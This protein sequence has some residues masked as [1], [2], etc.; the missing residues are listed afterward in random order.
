MCFITDLNRVQRD[1]GPVQT[2]LVV[3]KVQ[4]HGLPETGQRQGLVCACGQ[5]KAMDGVPHGVQDELI[6]L[7]KNSGHE[8]KCHCTQASCYRPESTLAGTSAS[9][10]F[11]HI[12]IRVVV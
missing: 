8:K 6:A 11:F 3:V 12:D 1:V 10:V 9:W 5:V 2:V 4:S 7:C